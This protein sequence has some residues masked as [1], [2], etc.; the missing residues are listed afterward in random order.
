MLWGSIVGFRFRVHSKGAMGLYNE[1][2][3][4]GLGL[5]FT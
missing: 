4:R 5:G 1:F 2:P 3:L